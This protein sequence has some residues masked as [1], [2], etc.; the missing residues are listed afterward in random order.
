VLDITT[1]SVAA[2]GNG[3]PR[4]RGYPGA[5]WR[6]ESIALAANPDPLVHHRTVVRTALDAL[7]Q[8]GHR[9]PDRAT[10]LANLFAESGPGPNWRSA[11]QAQMQ[12]AGQDQEQAEAALLAVLNQLGALAVKTT[13]IDDPAKETAAIEETLRHVSG[14]DR[15]VR[16]RAAQAAWL[17]HWKLQQHPPPG[18]IPKRPEM[19]PGSQRTDQLG[20]ISIRP[21]SPEIMTYV[22]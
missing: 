6:N 8:L 13:W 3:S 11:V 5:T 10:D 17:E 14:R 21:A 12:L 9:L 16:S 15:Q 2:E 22:R 1:F 18:L 4:S 7:H 19:P 20:V